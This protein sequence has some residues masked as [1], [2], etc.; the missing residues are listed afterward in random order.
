MSDN[1]TAGQK[2]WENL[3]YNCP[4]VWNKIGNDEIKNTFAFCEE[5]KSFLD[6]SKTEREFVARN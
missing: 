5:Y 6:K 3:S 4:N 1:K 2:L